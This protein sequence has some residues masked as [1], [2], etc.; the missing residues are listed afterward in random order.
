MT[1]RD[2]LGLAS[3]S[4]SVVCGGW[5]LSAAAPADAPDSLDA[6][7]RQE[8]L[9]AWTAGIL[10]DARDRTCDREL[11]EELGWLVSPILN[12][13]LYGYLATQDTAWLDRLIDWTDACTRRAVIEPDGFPGWPKG[14]G[15]G[16][17]SSEY[18]ADSLLGEAM[19][20]RPA[21]LAA[22]EIQS[23]PTLPTRYQ[24]WAKA[25]LATAERVFQ[26]WDS[27]NCWRAVAGVEGGGVWVVPEFGIDLKTGGWSAGY[28]KRSTEGFTNP[29][30]KLNHI[31]RW[32]LAL[33][34]ATGKKVYRDRAEAWFRVMKARLKTR[35]DGRFLVW[36]YWEPAGP[37]DF[38][39]DGSPKHWI[40]GHPNGGYY[41]ID[42]EAIADAHRHGVVFT[43]ADID[44]LVATNRDF[45]WNQKIEGARFQRIDGGEVDP[46]WKN[47]PG[48]LWESLMPYDATL[49]R[50]FIANHRPK[51]WGGLASTPWFLAG[52]P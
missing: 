14:D 5:H 45:M 23:G 35:D 40:G 48:L 25:L 47:S 27:R 30:N 16:G 13:F 20:L 24:D 28:A 6:T 17:A 4:T 49:R 44:R 39:A 2:F 46:R 32:M 7:H 51:S 33:H 12:G 50:I 15:G 11:G 41:A 1:R 8:W 3:A 36:N 21:V 29:D 18:S 31:A 19:F 9:N 22:R 26:K 34:A 38:N 43:R 37:W 42:V 10:A 52:M